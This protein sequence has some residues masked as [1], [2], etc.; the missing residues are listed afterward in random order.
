MIPQVLALLIPGSPNEHVIVNNIYVLA[1]VFFGMQ[2]ISACASY[3]YQ[4]L[5]V[6]LGVRMNG[7]LVSAIYEKTLRLS[8]RAQNQLHAGKLNTLL[9]G[10]VSLLSSAP[11]YAI[12]VVALGFQLVT[13]VVFL[14]VY[15]RLAALPALVLYAILFV[16]ETRVMPHI[17]TG[18]RAYAK[19]L[20]AR[21]KLL[22]DWLHAARFIKFEALEE[23]WRERVSTLRIA[24]AAADMKI[25]TVFGLFYASSSTRQYMIPAL[26]LLVY[27]AIN[28]IDPTVMFTSLALLDAIAGPSGMMNANIGQLLKVPVSYERITSFLLAVEVSAEDLPSVASAPAPDGIAVRLE[29]ARFTWEA[30]ASTDASV[31]PQ[32]PFSLHVSEKLEIPCGSL[33]AVVGKVGSGKSSLLSAL[34]GGMRKTG[35]VA[36][37]HGSLAYCPQDPWIMSGSVEGNILFGHHADSSRISLAVD[38]ACLGH[39]LDLMPHGMSTLI[40]EKGLNI[41]GGQRSRISLA[42]AVARD[43]DV[44]I[45]DSPTSALDAHVAK[46]VVDYTICT[47]LRGKTVIVATNQLHILP[48]TD[49]VVLMDRGKIGEVG[50]FKELMADPSSLL[51]DMMRGYAYDEPSDASKGQEDAVIRQALKTYDTQKAVAEDRKSGAFSWATFFSYFRAG[52]AFYFPGLASL[53]VLLITCAALTKIFI[54][55]WAKD[56]FQWS[57]HEYIRVYT[58]LCVTS[59]ITVISLVVFVFWN[60]FKAANVTHD[61][62][63]DGVQHASMPFFESTPAGQ[64]LNRLSV[65]VKELDGNLVINVFIVSREFSYLAAAAAVVAYSAPYILLLFLVIVLAALSLYRRFRPSYR[66][67]K[68]LNSVMLSPVLVHA[69]ETMTG[70]ESIKA[71]GVQAHFIH[72]LQHKLDRS[73]AASLFFQSAKAWLGLRLDL[74]TSAIVLAMILFGAAGV[75]D[76]VAVGLGL[77]GAISLGS[78]FN[79]VLVALTST[80]AMFNSVERLNHYRDLPSEPARMLPNDPASGSWPP[81]GK[82]VVENLS[83]R[84]AS[85]PDRAVIDGVSF[86]IAPGEKVAICGRTGSGKSSL[87]AA[88]FCMLEISGG[89]ILIDDRD[90]STMGLKALRSSLCIIPQEPTIFAGT[91]RSN[92]DLAGT[93]SDTALWGALTAVGL[94]DHISSLAGKLDAPLGD[95]LSAGQRQLLALARAVLARPT[96]LIMDEAASSLDQEGSIRVHELLDGVFASTTVLSVMHSLEH[97]ALFD[98]VML[99]EDGRLVEMDSPAKLLARESKFGELLDATGEANSACVRAQTQLR[100]DDS[101]DRTL[102][103]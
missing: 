96:V 78:L 5:A 67:L 18:V 66:E 7:I 58:A 53:L 83:L 85:R 64:I 71:Y 20:D 60:G 21:S 41:S 8:S 48:R 102:A 28:P 45:L 19:A 75:V 92:V 54:S 65:D 99:F 13:A 87:V 50:S 30:A 57:P 42:R 33:V 1:G 77:T 93:R 10:D 94:H 49:L 24:Q 91:V 46:K 47:L 103:M 81:K 63:M 15:L 40:G 38:A 97:V 80:E 39:D 79:G 90:I 100:S 68:R 27:A 2:L 6:T 74:M 101:S 84:Y 25:L 11:V 52:G 26:S 29:D 72:T 61:R 32:T 89:A 36:H 98:R 17:A 14:V 86:Q 43:A 69:S 9:S 88:F 95:A 37:I 3:N 76:G 70:R 51:S 62:A 82:I 4:Q 16:F 12:N 31:L 59:T 73:N 44:Y 34:V 23:V 56:S 22:R 55:F 35:G